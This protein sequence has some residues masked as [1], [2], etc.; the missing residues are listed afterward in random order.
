MRLLRLLNAFLERERQWWEPYEVV[1]EK[2]GLSKS[3]G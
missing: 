1:R 3:R 2:A